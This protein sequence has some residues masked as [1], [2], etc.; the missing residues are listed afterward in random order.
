MASSN[1]RKEDEEA[2]NELNIKNYPLFDSNYALCAFGTFQLFR[3]SEWMMLT[4]V[5]VL[6][7]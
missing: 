5:D 3:F 6:I 4:L 2:G 1:R 7:Y